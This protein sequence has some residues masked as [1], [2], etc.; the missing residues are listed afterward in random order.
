MAPR[1]VD[2]APAIDLIRVELSNDQVVDGAL[3]HEQRE[4]LPNFFNTVPDFFALNDGDS[5]V[6]VNKRHVIAVNL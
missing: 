5:V 2:I 1:S 6:Y 3:Q 4:R